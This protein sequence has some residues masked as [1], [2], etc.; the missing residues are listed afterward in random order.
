MLKVHCVVM[1]ICYKPNMN[2]SFLLLLK[3][4]FLVEKCVHLLQLK[5]SG[6]SLIIDKA[7]TRY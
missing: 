6:R 7:V 3:Y 1:A 4:C 5:P 2:L